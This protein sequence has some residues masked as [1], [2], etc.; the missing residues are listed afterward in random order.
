M[1]EHPVPCHI[2]GKIPKLMGINDDT[3]WTMGCNNGKCRER[4]CTPRT[5]IEPQFAVMAWNKQMEY[6]SNR[7]DVRTGEEPEE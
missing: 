6:L 4:P 2:C 5:Y 3:V 7:P 1:A